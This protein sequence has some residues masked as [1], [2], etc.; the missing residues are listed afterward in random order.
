MRK[1]QTQLQLAVG[2]SSLSVPTSSDS[3][4]RSLS[5]E[6]TESRG[7]SGSEHFWRGVSEQAAAG[8]GGRG[9]THFVFLRCL[10]CNVFLLLNGYARDLIRKPAEIRHYPVWHWTSSVY[11]IPVFILCLHRGAQL[12]EIIQTVIIAQSA[13]Q[14]SIP[15]NMARQ[16]KPF[17]AST[18]SQEKPKKQVI[19]KKRLDPANA[20]TYLPS[21]PKRHRTSAFQ[22]SLSYEELQ[23][24]KESSK[25]RLNDEDDEESMQERVRKVA[26]MIA[27]EGPQEVDSEES[28]VDSDE[29]W[30]S[31]GSDEERWGDV[32]KELEKGKGKKKAKDVV[33]KVGTDLL[34]AQSAEKTDSYHSLRSR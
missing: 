33:R 20:Y 30:E 17:T 24:A 32:F 16:S 1:D 23:Q 7:E 18:V 2:G 31:D 19:K 6:G 29:A 34:M 12:F 8:M 26:M 27:S 22:N 28:E 25:G 14:L 13:L 21:L 10:R 11:V 4:G 9:E 3:E 15:S 5:R